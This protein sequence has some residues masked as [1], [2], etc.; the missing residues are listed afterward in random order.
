[1]AIV[2]EPTAFISIMPSP[3]AVDVAVSAFTKPAVPATEATANDNA[4]AALNNTLLSLL[5][6]PSLFTIHS[7]FLALPDDSFS[8]LLP[9]YAPLNTAVIS[10]LSITCSSASAFTCPLA[11]A[12][13]QHNEQEQNHRTRYKRR[14]INRFYLQS[15]CNDS[16]FT[17][18][19]LHSMTSH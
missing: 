12:D 7:S 9:C 2:S 19:V 14:N 13:H 17:C 11:G 6:N 18:R 1:M 15:V 10:H 16:R 5:T 4:T 8:G 3:D